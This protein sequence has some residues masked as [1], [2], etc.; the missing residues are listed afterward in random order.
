MQCLIRDIPMHYEV[1]GSGRP[2]LLLHGFTPDHRLML[3]CME[4]LFQDNSGWQRIYPDLPGMG[5]TPGPTWLTTTDQMLEVVIEF[6]EQILPRQR[7]ALA[8]ESYGGYLAQALLH[9]Q[10]ERIS[11]LLQICPLVVPDE[12]QRR[13]PAHCVMKQE[14]GLLERLTPEEREQFEPMAVIQT[15]ATW[16]KFRDDIMPGLK[17]A[18]SAFLERLRATGYG[19]SD[20]SLAEAQSSYE[21]PILILTGRQDSSVGFEDAWQWAAGQPHASYVVLDRAGHNL[22]IEQPELFNALV[23]E[24]LERI[25]TGENS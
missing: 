15:S 5:Q 14:A 2:L 12:N 4:A 3:G 23:K 6:I 9:R 10:P 16:Q 7:Y 20:K 22:Q 1:H 11:G 25:E 8:G 21:G 18:D 24:W 19:F 13:R 17:L